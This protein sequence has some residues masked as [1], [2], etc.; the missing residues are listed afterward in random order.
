MAGFPLPCVYFRSCLPKD[1]FF[2]VTDSTSRSSLLPEALLSSQC[3]PPGTPWFLD[4]ITTRRFV[5]AHGVPRLSR[6]GA[7]NL[8]PPKPPVYPSV[9]IIGKKIMFMLFQLENL[10]IIQGPVQWDIEIYYF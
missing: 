7:I 5:V 9:R 3:G 8:A 2:N 4:L 6:S 10:L 1:L